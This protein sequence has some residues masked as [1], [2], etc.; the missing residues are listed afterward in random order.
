[1]HVMALF[2]IFFSLFCRTSCNMYNR[3]LAQIVATTDTLSLV[4]LCNLSKPEESR[5]SL[6]TGLTDVTHL[7]LDSSYGFGLY[8]NILPQKHVS[9][10]SVHNVSIRLWHCIGPA[11]KVYSCPTLMGVNETTQSIVESCTCH[12]FTTSI[13]LWS[14]NL[15]TCVAFCELVCNLSRSYIWARILHWS[16]CC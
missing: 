9:Y 12:F 10:C 5:D 11:L 16:W 14:R 13:L 4:L 1:M 2:L 6:I 7:E 8:Y 3:Y 15:M